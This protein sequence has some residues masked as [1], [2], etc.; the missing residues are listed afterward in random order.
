VITEAIYKALLLINLLLIIA[1][2]WLG[3]KLIR[4]YRIALLLTAIGLGVMFY[5]L[6]SLLNAPDLPG[7]LLGVKILVVT[8]IPLLVEFVVLLWIY[9]KRFHAS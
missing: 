8:I 1:S 9:R 4:P 2:F 3:P 6:V 7:Y 5:A